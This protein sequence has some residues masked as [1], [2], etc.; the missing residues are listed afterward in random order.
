MDLQ[1][2][3][4]E[5]CGE[6][7]GV[8]VIVDVLRA[9][10]TAAHALAAGAVEIVCVGTVA[11]AFAERERRPGSLVMGEVGG[12]PVDGFDLSN[13]PAALRTADLRGRSLIQRTSAGTQGVVGSVGATALFAASFACAG[14]TARAVAALQ[15]AAV[16]FVATGVDDRDGDEDVACADY[17]TA[18]LGGS[19]P[20]PSPFLARVRGSDAAQRFLSG[21]DPDFPAADV[22]AACR[23]D[24][25]DVAL[26]ADIEQDR[27]IL[28]PHR[29]PRSPATGQARSSGLAGAP[30]DSAA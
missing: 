11:H 9:F 18:L 28:R 2:V 26:R 12:R 23:L 30:P 22:E 27:P 25:V 14:A 29:P 19:Q 21:D 8:V 15:P 13:S 20:D 17:L 16:T 24:V 4:L 5:R 7:A 10:T 1:T 3:T 6:A